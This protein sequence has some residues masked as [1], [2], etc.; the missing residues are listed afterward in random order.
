M[1]REN[2]YTVEDSSSPKQNQDFDIF[3]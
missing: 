2:I 3:K 1:G